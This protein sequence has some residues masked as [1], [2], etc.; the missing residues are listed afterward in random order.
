MSTRN[1]GSVPKTQRKLEK[2]IN[3]VILVKI[4]KKNLRNIRK[5]L[6]KILKILGENF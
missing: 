4:L 6:A 3:Q 5:K 2:S 1:W